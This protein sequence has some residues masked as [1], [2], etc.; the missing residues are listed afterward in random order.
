MPK[1]EGALVLASFLLMHGIQE[2]K[3]ERPWFPMMLLGLEPGSGIILTQEMFPLSE[4][5]NN[6][7][8]TL[9]QLFKIFGGR[10]KQLGTHHPPLS[11]MLESICFELDIELVDLSGE[12][13]YYA[14]L[15]E[16]FS[17]F[18]G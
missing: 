4:L 9:L 16:A 17:S 15:M 6:V 11:D 12:E 2:K 7:E 13:P 3:T 18:G 10:P 14:E 1:L 5:P 8:K